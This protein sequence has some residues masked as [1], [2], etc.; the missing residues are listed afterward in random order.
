MFVERRAD[1]PCADAQHVALPGLAQV[2]DL[3]EA[4]AMLPVKS[5]WFQ[6][7]SRK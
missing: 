1:L 4:Q 5:A 7:A 6:A 2:I 3:E